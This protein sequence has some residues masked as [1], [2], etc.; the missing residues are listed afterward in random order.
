MNQISPSF[1]VALSTRNRDDWLSAPIIGIFDSKEPP[2]VEEKIAF[3]N[4]KIKGD[5]TIL[6]NGDS[7]EIQGRMSWPKSKI[8][9][10]SWSPIDPKGPSP[11]QEQLQNRIAFIQHGLQKISP[12]DPSGFE[13]GISLFRALRGENSSSIDCVN[14]LLYGSSD[15]FD[16]MIEK[17]VTW[18]KNEISQL[19]GELRA[20][21][22]NYVINQLAKGVLNTTKP[23]IFFCP[24]TAP[25]QLP[26]IYERLSGDSP[27]CPLAF[28]TLRKGEIKADGS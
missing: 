23:V 19:E 8:C 12:K 27:G 21:E 18:G 10:A 7:R 22:K 15:S 13:E 16:K 3:L 28:I 25:E 26:S 4:S 14:Q 5:R 2:S 1:T 24:Y 11:R 20:L 6:W 9:Y 17:Y